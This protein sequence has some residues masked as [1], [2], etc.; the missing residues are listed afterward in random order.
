MCVQ[1]KDG[2]TSWEHLCDLKESNPMEVAEYCISNHLTKEPVFIWWVPFALK[3]WDRIIKATQTRYQRKWQKYGIEIPKMVNCA[4]E[5]DQETGTDFWL[6]ALQLEMSKILPAVKV[7]DKNEAKPVRYQQIPCHIVFDVKMDFTRK[8]RYITGGH[9]TVDPEMPTYTSVVTWESIR[10]SLLLAA[11]N[12]LDIIGADVAGAYLNA[13]GHEKVFT[14]C[15][16]EF[17]AENV[18][19]IAII[20]KALY[21][22]KTSA[23]AWREQLLRTLREDLH[24]SPCLPDN[25][26]WLRKSTK[27]DGTRYYEMTFVYM[28]DLLVISHKPK[29]T[30]TQLDQHYHLKS[31]SIGI[32]TTYLGS[33]VKESH[34]S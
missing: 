10:I 20:T 23:F 4:L 27:P 19:K 34:K 18:G 33:Q 13:P 26:V 5:I 7:L 22:L 11:L 9:K 2:S 32:S 30:L 12:G 3:R 16:L 21:G 8:A 25:D 31:D 28:D 15:G 1:W 24:Y 14:I 29:E 17:G 6:K